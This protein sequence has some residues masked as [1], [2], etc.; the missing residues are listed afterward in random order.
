MNINISAAKEIVLRTVNRSGLVL[1]KV[2]PDIMVGVG[3]VGL[4]GATVLACRATLK[5][6]NTVDNSRDD[7]ETVKANP[8][9]T[10]NDLAKVYFRSSMDIARLYAPAIGVGISSITLI[11]GAHGIM[12]RRNA[13]LAAS[14]TALEQSYAAYRARVVEDLGPEKERELFTTPTPAE[15]TTSGISKLDFNG[16]NPTGVSPYARFF[17]ESS[18]EWEKNPEYNLTFLNAQ[19]AW[20]NEKLRAQGHLFLNEV[21]DALGLPRSQAGAIVGWV[22]GHPACDDFVDFGMY[23]VSTV[24]QRADFV[25]GYERAVL[26]DFNVQGPIYDLI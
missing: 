8:E 13:A 9:S 11:L 3:V 23:D 17:D 20:M 21:Y 1:R 6:E 16:E 25:N 15:Q 22:Y 18:S 14:Y 24:P 10:G 12:H 26:L 2:S 5:L 4:V 7:I 19:Q